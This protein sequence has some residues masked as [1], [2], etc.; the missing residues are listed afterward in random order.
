VIPP[1]LLLDTNVLIHLARDNSIGRII[2]A[3]FGLRNPAQVPLLS[4]VTVGEALAFARKRDWGTAKTD[5]LQTLLRELIVVDVNSEPILQGYAEID[6]YLTRRGNPIEQNDIW[7]AATAR[8]TNSLLLTTDK[9][10]NV[11]HPAYLNRVWID[12]RAPHA[13]NSPESP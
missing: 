7:I 10:F 6:T 12:P 4:I 8:A 5:Q 9:D 13:L 2:D 11:L 3:R 1:N